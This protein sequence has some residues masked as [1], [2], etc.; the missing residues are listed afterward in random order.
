MK[1]LRLLRVKHYIKNILIFFPMIFSGHSTNLSVLYRNIIGFIT[2][3]FSASIIYIF[4]D[5]CDLEKDKQHP[6]KRKRPLAAGTIT[7]FQAKFI[8]FILL[9]II[10]FLSYNFNQN[11]IGYLIIYLCSNF[12][13]SQGGKNIPLLDV[14]LLTLGYLLRLGYGGV[15][16]ETEISNWMFLTVLSA[17]FYMGFGKRRNELLQFG[18]NS[19]TCLSLYTNEFLNNSC[20]MFIV[21][22]IVFYSLTCSDKTTFVARHGANFIYTVPIMILICLRYNMILNSG[23]SDGDPIEIVLGDKILII[24]I[25]FHLGI[26]FILLHSIENKI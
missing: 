7:I 22:T 17:A 4:N 19:R 1:I 25:L 2:F 16:S 21:L 10:I 8:I 18:S 24:L 12:I 5:I 15:I 20:Q 13:Y 23:N 14:T 11:S 3:S 26:S 6:L 9:I